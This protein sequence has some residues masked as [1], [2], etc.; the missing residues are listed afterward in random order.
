M[1]KKTVLGSFCVDGLPSGM[2]Q[3]LWAPD[4]GGVILKTNVMDIG[5][6]LV[7]HVFVKEHQLVFI[8]GFLFVFES[9]VCNI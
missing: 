6:D 8:G 2:P 1:G 9:F 7:S 4:D 3:G 5:C